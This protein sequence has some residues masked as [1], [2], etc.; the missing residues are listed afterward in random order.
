[1]PNH[2][3]SWLACCF[4][5]PILCCL[6]LSSGSY[7]D[8]NVRDV[9]FKL[10]LARPWLLQ[11]QR[12]NAF[13]CKVMYVSLHVYVSLHAHCRH[14]LQ[15]RTCREQCHKG[16]KSKPK[17]KPK[18]L[19]RPAR[20]IDRWPR[21]CFSHPLHHS[22]TQT[23]TCIHNSDTTRSRTRFRVARTRSSYGLTRELEPG[24]TF[25]DAVER[26]KKAFTSNGFGLPPGEEEPPCLPLS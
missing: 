23:P 12:T 19:A 14:T 2:T 20:S 16:T 8:V 5:K 15:R 6:T 25:A 7:D 9:R 11:H 24:T 21:Y 4:L 26:T 3:I 22:C 18:P 17:P 13:V 1:M 10:L